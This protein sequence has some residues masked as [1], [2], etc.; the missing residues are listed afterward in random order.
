VFISI[1]ALNDISWITLLNRVGCEASDLAG[2]TRPAKT[3]SLIHT[4]IVEGLF[5]VLEQAVREQAARQA[6]I[7][8]LLTQLIE[9]ASKYNWDQV[10]DLGERIGSLRWSVVG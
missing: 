8:D 7:A 6:E 3:R 1:N 2:T 4:M 10:I 9:A 5:G